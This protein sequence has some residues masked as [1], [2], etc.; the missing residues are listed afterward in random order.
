MPVSVVIPTRNR[1]ES[2]RRLLR[3]L[4][5]QTYPLHQVII[6]DSS[7]GD[8][9]HDIRG[10]FP[11]LPLLHLRSE[12]HVCLQRNLGIRAASTDYIFL[13]DDDIE[14]P[15]DYV[16]NLM[17]FLTAHSETGAISGL[18]LEPT[19]NGGF[20][21]GNRPLKP[22]GLLVAFTFQLSVWGDV[23]RIKAPVLMVPLMKVLQKYYANRGNR[24]TL[25]GWPLFTQVSRP[26]CRAAV[27]GLGASIVRR[28]WL[29]NSPFSEVLDTHGIG[30][31]FGVALG[32]PGEQPIVVLPDTRVKHHKS[33]DNRLNRGATYL[34]RVLALDYF[35]KRDPR[36]SMMN[37]IFLLWSVL[38]HCVVMAVRRDPE[39]R[40]SSAM[41]FLSILFH[42][43]P[44]V[45]KSL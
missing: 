29:L 24:L 18:L 40:S 36:F 42:R 5:A 25:A 10:M 6:V 1:P 41:A 33:A 23:E 15:H 17:E 27:Y 39:L 19:R 38:G 30:D 2:L 4:E 44:L 26:S 34:R 45:R 20:D 14:P 9:A 11:S 3:S 37:R 22:T 31:N 43:N 35:M 13:C 21:D 32:F 16:G 8:N 12:P 28:Q 7:D